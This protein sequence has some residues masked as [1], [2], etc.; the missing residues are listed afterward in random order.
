[1]KITRAYVHDRAGQGHNGKDE[2]RG[3]CGDVHREIQEENQGRNVYDSSADTKKTRGEAD[4]KA[5]GNAHQGIEIIIKFFSG[6][7]HQVARCRRVMGVGPAPA[8][9]FERSTKEQKHSGS[10][11]QHPEDSV[12]QGPGYRRGAERSNDGPGDRCSGEYQSYL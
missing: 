4:S 8:I 9:M 3:G 6:S 11:E 12:E 10:Q 2:M 1:M 7:C 5:N